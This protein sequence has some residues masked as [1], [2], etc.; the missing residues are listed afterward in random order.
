MG[1]LGEN[2]WN[3]YQRQNS[4]YFNNIRYEYCPNGSVQ[5]GAQLI[6]ELR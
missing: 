6:I 4:P 3:N 2:R 1:D 5:D